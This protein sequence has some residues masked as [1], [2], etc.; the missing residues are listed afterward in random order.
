MNNI[1]GIIFSTS[2]GYAVL[3]VMT[4]ILFAALG[5]V[6]S[7]RAGVTNIALEGIN[8][9]L[10]LVVELGAGEVVG[11]LIDVYPNKREE[12]VITYSPDK[13]NK[14]LG[15]TIS[16]DTMINIFEKNLFRTSSS[17]P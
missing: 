7:D 17:H 9:A 3:R 16:E 1:F 6:I 15:I 8:K 2:F 11:E 5:S 12:V 14:L 10:E 4:P 13:I